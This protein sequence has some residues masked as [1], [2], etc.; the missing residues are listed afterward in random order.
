MKHQIIYKKPVNQYL[1]TLVVTLIL[2]TFALCSKAQLNPFQTMY[3]QNQYMYN[4]AMA[5]LTNGLNVNLDYRQQWSSFPGAPKTG[6]LTA[7][8]QAADKVGLGLNVTDDQSGLIRSTRAMATY[9][10][11]LPLSDKTEHLSFGLS[12]GINDSRVDYNKINGDLSDVEIGL[13]N[14]LKPYVDGDFGI[15]YTSERLY[16]GGALPN[17]RSAFFKTSDT[18][19]DADRMLFMAA[20]SYKIPIDEVTRTFTL[21]PLA[22]YRIVKGYKDIVD[23]GANFSVNNYGLYMQ[24]IYHSDQSMAVGFGLDQNTYALNFSYNIETGQIRNYTVGAFELGIK[25]R[26]PKK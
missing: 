8:F 16:I 5:G 6:S 24:G 9:A 11:H 7:D 23:V 25:L 21:E 20:T 2:T 1:K 4:P 19:F 3:F 26:I 17:L 13:Y 14:Q 12:L 15:A 18:R 22:A 10:Y